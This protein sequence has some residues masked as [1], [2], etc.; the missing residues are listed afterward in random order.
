MKF[1][2]FGLTIMVREMVFGC[3]RVRLTVG[4]YVRIR[5]VSGSG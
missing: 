2:G 5:K 1:G 3:V 4:I